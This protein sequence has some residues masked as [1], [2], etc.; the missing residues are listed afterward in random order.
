MLPLRLQTLLKVQ[1]E[2]RELAVR[3]QLLKGAALLVGI[4]A[5]AALPLAITDPRSSSRVILGTLGLACGCGV[6]F[7]L[8]HRRAIAPGGMLLTGM[9]LVYLSLHRP[10]LLLTRPHG[11]A[12]FI[13]VLVASLISGPTAALICGVIAL[14]MLGLIS[15]LSGI[16]WTVDTFVIA[17]IIAM[18]TGLLWLIVRTLEQ[19]R[20]ERADAEQQVRATLDVLAQE[21]ATSERARREHRAVLDATGEAMALVSPD[22]QLMTINRR[23]TEFFG[24]HADDVLGQHIT[25]LQATVE[26]IF[27]EPDE[28]RNLV[29]ASVTDV[30]RQFTTILG[31]QW[32]NRR[33]LELFSTPVQGVDNKPVG[34][35]YVFRDITREREVD[36]MKSDFVALAS[37]E[38]RTPLNAINGFVSLLLDGAAGPLSEQ[39]GHL[40]G[41]AKRNSDRLTVLVT[42]LLDLSRIESG[43]IELQCTALN[44]ATLIRHVA[45]LLHG[46]LEAKQQRLML[47][48]PEGLPD[49]SGDPDRVVQILLNLLSNAHK[50]TPAHGHITVAAHAEQEYLQVDI[51]DTG[52]G[53]APDEQSQ[54][55]TK[56]FRVQ[57]HMT[58]D[59]G[60]TGLGLAI[61]RSLIDLHGGEIAVQSTQG[62]GSTFSFTLPYA[63]PVRHSER[64]VVG[65]TTT[66]EQAPPALE[67]RCRLGDGG[68]DNRGWPG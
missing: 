10:D 52:V 49:V 17:F 50:Y 41:V 44:I 46:E 32:P 25:A 35:L 9:L 55:F 16:P 57:N 4:I 5:L 11:A 23:L 15:Q 19:F 29:A 65:H 14:I 30:E 56:F 27:A 33:D 8:A 22:G 62:Q 64:A 20:A 39:Q 61:T 31:Q 63:T 24:V 67:R 18:A 6:V 36:R 28:V 59:V 60:G 37:H 1:S 7:L 12:F 42:D 51:H 3:G 45:T 53:L 34:R 66:P 38:L 48:L 40:L 2:D 54:I 26:R 58:Q 47:E 43:K 21:Y 68:S 13:P